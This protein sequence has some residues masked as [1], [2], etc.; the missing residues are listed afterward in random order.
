MFNF[1][2]YYFYEP[3]RILSCDRTKIL[4]NYTFMLNYNSSLTFSIIG[5]LHVKRIE[6]A[7]KD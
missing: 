4:K 6:S 1:S 3:N 7:I 2:K 5:I